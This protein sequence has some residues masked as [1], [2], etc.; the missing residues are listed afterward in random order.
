[1]PRLCEFYPGICFTTEE[2][3]RRNLSEVSRK[4]LVYISRVEQEITRVQTATGLT[5][6]GNST[7]HIYT[8]T[9]HRTTQLTNWEECGPCPVFASF[10]L[11]FA[12]QLRKSTEKPQSG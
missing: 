8:Q 1:M 4:V 3:A 10:T 12:L 9:I 6:G 5:S 7:V 11:E 2:K